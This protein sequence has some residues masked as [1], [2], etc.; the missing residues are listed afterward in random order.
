MGVFVTFLTF[1]V[2]EL[3]EIAVM[4]VFNVCLCFIFDTQFIDVVN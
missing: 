3:C 2:Q 1:V 4:V